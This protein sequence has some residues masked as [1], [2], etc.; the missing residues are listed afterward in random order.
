MT[1]AGYRDLDWQDSFKK[2]KRVDYKMDRFLTDK[3]KNMKNQL[4]L[5]FTVSISGESRV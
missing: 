5:E 4:A 1:L 2:T 3:C